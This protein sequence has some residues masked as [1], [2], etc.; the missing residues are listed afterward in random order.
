MLVA[1]AT[2]TAARASTPEAIS[3]SRN[4][5][6][7]T[8]PV[9]SK[10]LPAPRHPAGVFPWLQTVVI[11]RK[12]GYNQHVKRTHFA[13]LSHALLTVGQCHL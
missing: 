11:S 6:L 2:A 5:L 10:K 8:T 7:I 1:T 12:P 4:D 3:F 9:E 13:Q